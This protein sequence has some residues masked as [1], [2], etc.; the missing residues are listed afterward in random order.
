[1]LMNVSGN[2]KGGLS[3]GKAIS[4]GCKAAES[5]ISYL[6]SYSDDKLKG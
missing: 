1:M 5:V 3:V 6:D 4:S 2:H